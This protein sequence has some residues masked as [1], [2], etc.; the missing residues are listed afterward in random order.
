MGEAKEFSAG[1][2]ALGYTLL[3]MFAAA[4]LGLMFVGARLVMMGMLAPR[5]QGGYAILMIAAG[6]AALYVPL[7]VGFAMLQRRFNPGAYAARAAARSQEPKAQTAGIRVVYAVLWSVGAVLWTY[8][9]WHG[10]GIGPVKW[11]VAVVAWVIAGLYVKDAV[12][13]GGRG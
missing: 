13:A 2:R 1:R 3:V 5:S 8:S 10:H 6:A 4:L 9:A 12:S 7:R 11:A